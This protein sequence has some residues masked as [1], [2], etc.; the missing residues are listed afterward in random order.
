MAEAEAELELSPQEELSVADEVAEIL[1][2]AGVDEPQPEA[3]AAADAEADADTDE[4][5]R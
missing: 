1:V 2:E 3:D 5:Q 4:A